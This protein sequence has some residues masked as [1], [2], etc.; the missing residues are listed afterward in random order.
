MQVRELA[1]TGV[2]TTT[3]AADTVASAAV[4]EVARR[5]RLVFL[6]VLTLLIYSVAGCLLFSAVSW[7]LSSLSRSA[8]LILRLASSSC[9]TRHLA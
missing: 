7:L 2:A 1:L 6:V 9:P 8:S 5:L 4:V 3:A